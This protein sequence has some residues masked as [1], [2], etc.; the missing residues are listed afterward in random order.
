MATFNSPP[1]WPEPPTPDWRPQAG[2]KPDPSWPPAPPGWAFW[3]NARGL[4]A[5]GPNG[6]YGAEPPTKL[7]AGWVAGGVAFIV[8]LAAIG[9][10]NSAPAASST[11]AATVT[12]A[13]PTVTVGGPTVTIPGP[14]ATVT[15]APLPAVTVTAKAPQATTRT[16]APGPFAQST[17]STK[18]SATRT[19]EAPTAVYYA[20]CAEA[21][22]AGAAP[23]YAGEPGYS[24]KLDR[25]HDGVACE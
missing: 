14:T 13:G 21:R 20:S 10:S 2:W 7:V 23:L 25:D 5:R 3:L 6:L 4:R 16:T 1:G 15:A 22:A 18:P 9:G 19:T 24:S 17:K 8:L 12:V 11:P